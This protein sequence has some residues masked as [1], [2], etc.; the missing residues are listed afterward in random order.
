MH[1]CDDAGLP[2]SM[3]SV[4]KRFVAT[5]SSKAVAFIVGLATAGIVPR[6][7][8]PLQYGNY[9][10]L[11]STFLEVKNLTDLGVSSAFFTDACKNKRTGIVAL[12][13]L[14]WE[15]LQNAVIV[16]GIAVSVYLGWAGEIWP[17]QEPRII[18]CV[19]GVSMLTILE[20]RFLSLADAKALTVYAQVAKTVCYLLQV[21]LVVSLF[22]ADRL[23]LRAYIV[24]NY[25]VLS[26]SVTIL[27]VYFFAKRDSLFVNDCTKAA[28]RETVRYMR[29]YCS[30]LAIYTI[31]GFLYAFF[32]RWF[33]QRTG[34]G[35]QHGYYSLA[36]NGSQIIMIFSCSM[37]PIFWREMSA[38]F[39][40]GDFGR[41]RQF[42][43]KNHKLF[44]SITCFISAFMCIQAA[45]IVRLFA[46]ESF[47]AAVWP[48]ML[49]VFYPAHQTFGQLGGT[50]F[51]ATDRT[52][53]LRNIATLCMV[54]GA[55]LTYF[56]VA[57]RVGRVPGLGLGSLGLAIQMLLFQVVYVN[58]LL[59][60]N[61]RYLSLSYPHYLWYQVW[62]IALFLLL[63]ALSSALGFSVSSFLPLPKNAAGM[64]AF[65]ASGTIYAAL[66]MLSVLSYPAICGVEREE[67]RSIL[68]KILAVRIIR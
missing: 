43:E 34:G 50:M 28:V 30:P 46:G 19:A 1:L 54:A 33:L 62:V 11:N 24:L 57:P 55:A 38:S 53:Q 58:V 41:I 14:L 17:Q 67:M 52:L 45:F 68:G 15:L 16:T 8:G 48:F 51:L 59:F 39:G 61:C 37:T 9:Q 56:L 2:G 25:V 32:N 66:G 63:A 4:K 6:S 26:V 36:F 60:S 40:D 3:D 23:D 13:F 21:A 27:C 47:S 65:V 10:F 35:T 49:M 22:L 18:F 7:L 20:G 12:L 64:V 31:V 44:F 42:F 29:S 5:F